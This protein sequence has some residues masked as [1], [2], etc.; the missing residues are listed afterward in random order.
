MH[1]T[2]KLMDELNITRQQAEG[3][4]GLLLQHAQAKLNDEQFQRVADAIPAISDVVG[5]A[6]RPAHIA[7]WRLLWWRWFT[8]WRTLASSRPAFEQLALDRPTIDQCI[9]VIGAHFREHGDPQV[10][11][12]VRQALGASRP[13]RSASRPIR[14]ATGEPSA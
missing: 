7:W 1:L 11:A 14:S 13:S 2:E 5:K 3:G 10:E 9:A 4:A 12:H 8:P 6:V